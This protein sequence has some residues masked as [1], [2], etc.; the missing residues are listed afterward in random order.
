[1][2]SLAIVEAVRIDAASQ[3]TARATQLAD[4]YGRARFA[5]AT[6]EGLERKYRLEP[7]PDVLSQFN[8]AASDYEAALHDVTRL[9]T[10]IDRALV[11]G[12]VGR[13]RG[14]RVAI[15]RLFDAVDSHDTRRVLDID[16][17]QVD[18]PFHAIEAKVDEV[19][20]VHR[21]IALRQTTALSDHASLIKVA[22]PIASLLGMALLTLFAM[23]LV[24]EGRRDATREAEVLILAK[25]ALED[26]LT[27]LSNR[28]KL[29]QDLDRG[30]ARA[31]ASAPLVLVV[32]DLDGF[33]DYNDA[34]GHPA[35]DALL[36]RL[37]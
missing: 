17:H 28:R 20:A 7:G 26:S 25:A 31:S 12:L 36:A 6:E 1:M 11:H 37:G 2:T 19:A 32:F 30:L 34:F 33:K 14:Y 21:I 5:V 8:L 29:A 24:R 3:A 13:Q 35:G 4:A 15:R 10:G 22:T 18:P 9:G 16:A 23:L 27:G